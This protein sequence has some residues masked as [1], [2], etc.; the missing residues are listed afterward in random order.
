ME[1]QALRQARE[2]RGWSQRDVA[3]Q[4]GTNR[5][6]VTR[7]ERGLAFPSP[8]FRQK[9]CALF[10]MTLSELGLFKEKKSWSPPPSPC[11]N[12]PYY[13]NPFFTGREDMLRLLSVRLKNSNARKGV[14]IVALSG[15]GGV[16]KTQL[17]IEYAY[18]YRSKYQAILWVQADSH[19]TLL[20]DFGNLMHVLQLEGKD[21]QD[22]SSAI[23]A[24]QCWLAE[25]G[26]W[27]LIFDNVEDREAIRSLI[28]A[29]GWG[30]VL[31]TT[32]HHATNTL[33]DH[34][35][36]DVMTPEEGTL[37]LLYRAKIIPATISPT[38]IPLPDLQAAQSLSHLMDNLPLALDQAGAY[39]EETGCNIA[40]YLKRYQNRQLQLLQR[41]GSSA[42]HPSSVAATWLI[43]FEKL[44]Q[45]NPT[46]VTLLQLCALLHPDAIPEEIFIAVLPP[47]LQP[48]ATD[49]FHLDTLIN[50]LYTF[51]LI[52][53]HPETGTLSLHR[54]VQTVL[55]A[56]M[57]EHTQ[58]QQAEYLVRAVNALFP[59]CRSSDWSLCHRYL[60]QALA[61]AKL[62]QQWRLTFPA[63]AR[64]LCQTGAYLQARASYEQ[65]AQLYQ[66][67]LDIYQQLSS[68][69]QPEGARCLFALATLYDAQGRMQEAEALYQ[70]V[71]AFQT[72]ALGSSHPE[73]AQTLNTLALF[74]YKQD[75]YA[76]AEPLYRQVLC[77]CQQTGTSEHP[78]AAQCLSNLGTLYREQGNYRQAEMLQQQALHL[79]EQVFGPDHL[80]VAA[81]YRSL[82]ILAHEQ[83]DF[84]RAHLLYQQA[85][86]IREAELGPDHPEVALILRGLG[87][88][89]YG[90]RN[91][92]QAE[93]YYRRV[94][95]IRQ[96]ALRPG[97]PSFGDVFTLLA[98]L[99]V[100]QER[101]SEA[102][103]Y[104]HSALE[105]WE[106]MFDP[107]SP[108]LAHCFNGL[109]EVAMGQG[110]YAEAEALC[111]RALTIMRETFG[112]RHQYIAQSLHVLAELRCA[113]E[114]YGQAEALYQQALDILEHNF[115]N[116]HPRIALSLHGLAITY[117]KQA[118][119]S[120]VLPL[121]QRMLTIYA[122][123]LP[124]EHPDV[125]HAQQQCT[126]LQL[127]VERQA[128]AEI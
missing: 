12:V 125:I 55:K 98:E 99:A 107:D 52:R 84:H 105:I 95:H 78:E 40:G 124:T 70:D 53:R 44:K 119:Y 3:E 26:S 36:V 45:I 38:A 32:R 118:L 75:K 23:K 111:Q 104:F 127:Q 39:I 57:N 2:N 6:T 22:Q 128:A 79:R 51:S 88:L 77:I 123:F 112:E 13:R 8:Y 30:H 85:L 72:H 96:R 62:I 67:A 29:T 66:Q 63:A 34:I 108:D 27:L 21:K 122:Q 93:A 116:L 120:Q 25:R 15:L 41:R 76:Q 61:C 42:D 68:I 46:A 54:L 64:L 115:G 126:R 16:G 109:A 20:A 71:L 89:S 117:E 33:A 94:L 80:E 113:Q 35:E 47:L 90:Q 110:D 50:V 19:T 56:T 106:P 69:E 31:L 74:Y 1:N 101:W 11:W 43:S 73:I 81:S 37:F 28:P 100:A 102:K 114:R 97:H 86:S 103:G 87:L 83:G 121:Y 48:I 82:A 24:V 65:A 91:Y 9:L 59:D 7:W 4:I 18:R 14:H 60:P 5:F 10:D 17:A 49:L 92:P 58:Q